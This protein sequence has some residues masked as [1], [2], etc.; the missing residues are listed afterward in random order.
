M[1]TVYIG[2]KGFEA[3]KKTV[4]AIAKDSNNKSIKNG[5]QISHVHVAVIFR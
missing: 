1:I 4:A 2:R 3:R 5:C